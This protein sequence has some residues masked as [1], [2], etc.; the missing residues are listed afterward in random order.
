MRVERVVE[1]ALPS[2]ETKSPQR[3]D[4]VVL[5]MMRA[6]MQRNVMTV[7]GVVSQEEHY[8][9]QHVKLK[10]NLFPQDGVRTCRVQLKF[11]CMG[12]T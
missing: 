7:V 11:Y 9:A 10:R 3:V 8:C 6:S 12:A 4:I 2:N 1:A 5:R